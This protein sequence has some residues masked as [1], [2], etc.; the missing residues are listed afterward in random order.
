MS[1]NNKGSWKNSTDNA[2][3]SVILHTI[4]TLG[5]T[6]H[7]QDTSINTIRLV[8]FGPWDTAKMHIYGYGSR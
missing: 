3:T 1:S 5:S 6:L 7:V 4:D 8:K 2:T